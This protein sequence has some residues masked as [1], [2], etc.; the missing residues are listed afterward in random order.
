M[1]KNEVI[2]QLSKVF[3]QHGYEGATLTQLSQATGLGKASLY[4]HFPRGKEEMAAAVLSY[5]NNWMAANIIAPLQ[6]RESLAALRIDAMTKKVNELYSCGKQPCL[7]AV[8]AL[9]E[10]QEL[11]QAQIQQALKLWIDTLA[12]VLVDAGLDEQVARTRAEDAVIKIQGALIVAQG[13]KDVAPFERVLQHLPEEL[14]K[15]RS[16]LS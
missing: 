3:R 13:L 1:V 8:L 16:N 2:I 9:G 5:A 4:H 14:L 10:S 6:D 11:F 7:L 12:D 15:K